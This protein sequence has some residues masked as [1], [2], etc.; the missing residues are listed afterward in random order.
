MHPH[1]DRRIK[2]KEQG[3]RLPIASSRSRLWQLLSAP[4]EQNLLHCSDSSIRSFGF[5]RLDQ[6]ICFRRKQRFAPVDRISVWCFGLSV[7]SAN[8]FRLTPKKTSWK[9]CACVSDIRYSYFPSSFHF[10]PTLFFKWMSTDIELGLLVKVCC[11]PSKCGFLPVKFTG[12]FKL[13]IMRLDLFHRCGMT[14]GKKDS[15]RRHHLNNISAIYL[16]RLAI[17]N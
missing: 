11:L 2:L 1:H 10:S 14:S 16:I 7:F 9:C 6:C 15:S 8:S 17:S 4:L 5:F 3:H 13:D 12:I